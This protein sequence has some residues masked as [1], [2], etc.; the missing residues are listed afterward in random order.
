MGLVKRNSNLAPREAAEVAPELDRVALL[1]DLLSPRAELRRAAA[2]ALARDPASALPL[3]DRLAKEPEESVRQAIL[4]S[5]IPL[6][7]AQIGARL[8]ELLRSE[9]AS[10][11]SAV[12]EA[13]ALMPDAAWPSIRAALADADS[14]VR[15]LT[16]TAVATMPHSLVPTCLVEVVER[17]EHPN[18]I[19]AAVEGLLECGDKEAIPA[20]EAARARFS[21][22]P[23]LKFLIDQTIKLLSR[24]R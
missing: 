7:T 20:L 13:L 8:V 3:C 5:L 11:R 22:S 10:L 1:A 16:V 12:G 4:A 17:D 19:A 2:H 9:D 18:V 6:A 21:T 15:I 23:F 24:R 14:D